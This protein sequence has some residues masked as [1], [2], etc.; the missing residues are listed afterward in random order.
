MTVD[1]AVLERKA[2]E[3]QA[4]IA[5][6]FVAKARELA[7][8]IAHLSTETDDP[9]A[10]CLITAADLATGDMPPERRFNGRL[11]DED[12]MPGVGILPAGEVG[13]LAGSAG[14][15]KSMIA[16]G[17][18]V[19]VAFGSPALGA[20]D[21]RQG[22]VMYVSTEDDAS[23]LW[24]RLEL[25]ARR[26]IR[27]MGTPSGEYVTECMRRIDFVIRPKGADWSLVDA[28]GRETAVMTALRARIATGGYSLVILDTLS[29][30]GND[31][32]EKSPT[33]SRRFVEGLEAL[34]AS[35]GEPTI[36]LVHHARKAE[37]GGRKKGD[38]PDD[39]TAD[40]IR[41]TSGLVGGVRF[42]WTL[43]PKGDDTVRL[44]QVKANYAPTTGVELHR[45]ERGVIWGRAK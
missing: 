42:A 37:T 44:A 41:G 23:E 36:L 25:Y 14:G 45:A 16:M 28:N 10:G 2:A 34:A 12:G 13:I 32:L 38:E 22:R 35:P 33:A 31:E 8:V 4:M 40:S 43:Q 19:G 3:L 26:T 39:L 9:L 5:G 6:G 30:L 20:I 1:R 15:G 18:A 17:L 29:R 11:I 27:A 7:E 21:V 24:R